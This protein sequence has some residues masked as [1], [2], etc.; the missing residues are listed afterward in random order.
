MKKKKWMPD[1][2]DAAMKKALLKK[3]EGFIAK[4]AECAKLGDEIW[5]MTY[6]QSAMKMLE[7][8][9]HL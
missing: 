6:L 9:R 1:K 2:Q 5:T 7:A 8:V 4:A 3:A